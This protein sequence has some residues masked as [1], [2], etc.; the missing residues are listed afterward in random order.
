MIF[1]DQFLRNDV[2]MRQ[3][4]MEMELACGGLALSVCG[5]FLQ[6]PPPV[7]KDGSR[8]SLAMK[9]T[10]SGDEAADGCMDA[11]DVKVHQ[12]K[13]SKQVEGHQGFIL[14]RSIERVVSLG[15]N[16]RAPGVLSRLQSE[17]RVGRIS[18]AM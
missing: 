7:A 12:Q 16:V 3:A 1:A 11:D 5:D 13:R 14:W 9:P 4:K 15:V 10:E 18:D 8:K 2:R 6:L 17:M